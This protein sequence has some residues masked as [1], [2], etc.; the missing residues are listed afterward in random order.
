MPPRRARSASVAS[1]A[2]AP[3]GTPRRSSRPSIVP[4]LAIN[5][6]PSKPKAVAVKKTAA[7]KGRGRAASPVEEDSDEESDDGASTASGSRKRKAPTAKAAAPRKKAAAAPRVIKAKPKRAPIVG[8]NP[9]AN[10]FDP[11]PLHSAFDFDIPKLTPAEEAPRTAFVYGNGDF[12]QHGMG[13]DEDADSDDE[14]PKKQKVL[15]EIP[16][17]RLHTLIEEKIG[18]GEKGWEK[19]LASLEC[20]GM[21]TL[22]I[23][24]K[25]QVWSW[26]INDNAALGRITSIPGVDAETLETCPM[27]VQGLG[28]EDFKAVRVAAGDSVSLAVSDNG[29]LRCWGSFRHSEGL[30]GFDGSAGSALTQLKPVALKN[31]E[32]HTIVQLATGDD[33]FVALTSEGKVFACGN[34]EQ[35]QLGRKIIQRHRTH[36]LTPERLALKNI[37]LVGSGAYHSFAVNKDGEVYA[38]GLN[39]FHQTGVSDDDGG[40]EEIISTP[41]IVESLLPKHHGGARVVQIAGG[42]HH[43]MFLFSNGEVWGVGRSDGSEMG[44][45]KDHP[46]MKAMKEREEEAL[47][48]RRK[49]EVEEREKLAVEPTEDDEG[50][51]GPPLSGIELDLKAKENAAQLIPLPNPFVPLPTKISFPSDT[52]NGDDT[53]II[54][55]ATGTRQ[56]F[57]VSS[58]GAVF[59]WGFGN[60]AQLGLGDE[61]EAETPTRITSKSM[62]GFRV[63]S[64][65]AGGQHSVVVAQR[66][67]GAQPSL[68]QKKAEEKKVEEKKVEEPKE[69][70]EEPE[71]AE[72]TKEN[73][74][75]EMEAANGAEEEK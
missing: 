36:G 1:A 21:H 74:D 31:I 46:E 14:K 32:G 69:K 28:E 43:S 42:V 10:R 23:D 18:K 8:I 48:E 11:F 41:T 49:K 13:W 67:E 34:G 20:G 44:L 52:D 16:R 47:V 75:V 65:A 2:A 62:K 17:P 12:G 3:A 64:A 30:L 39:S 9:I 54:Q 73:G 45:G 19:G 53:K 5:P 56:N 61:E 29:E 72:E 60:T 15:C 70:A 27:L 4:N 50:E 33:H 71:K 51:P 59:A 22:A 25:G 68:Y 58:R 37:V 66:G 57:G 55:L 26:G 6:S 38:W 35:C 63:L 7:K 40:W 24:G